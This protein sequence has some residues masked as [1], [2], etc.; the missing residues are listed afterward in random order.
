MAIKLAIDL[1]NAATMPISYEAAVPRLHPIKSVIELFPNLVSLEEK[2]PGRFYWRLKPIGPSGFEQKVTFATDI[3]LDLKTGF[4][5]VRPVAGEGNAIINGDW[6]MVKQGDKTQ[7]QMHTWG[8]L[9]LALPFFLKTPAKPI[10]VYEFKNM[11][12]KFIRNLEREALS[13]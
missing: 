9:N 11:L 6:R 12:D 4:I 1:N 10:V 5:Q 8:E 13:A 2:T 7:V 3:T